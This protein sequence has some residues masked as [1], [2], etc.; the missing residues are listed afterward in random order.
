M[1]LV[2]EGFGEEVCFEREGCDGAAGQEIHSERG[3]SLREDS[4][5]NKKC[6]GGQPWKKPGRGSWRRQV[7]WVV[8]ADS[9]T[10]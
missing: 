3:C 10:A 4:G 6:G 8:A 5:A 2:K 9:Q 7:A 1:G